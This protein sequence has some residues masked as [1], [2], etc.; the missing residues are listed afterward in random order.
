MKKL[1]FAG[2]CSLNAMSTI[3]MDNTEQRILLLEQQLHALKTELQQQKQVQ[4]ELQHS[5]VAVQQDVHTH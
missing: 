4:T 1:L 2:A 3:A 5:Q